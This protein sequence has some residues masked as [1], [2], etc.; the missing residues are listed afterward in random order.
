MDS[1]PLC[2]LQAGVHLNSVMKEETEE[3][4]WLVILE[5]SGGSGVGHIPPSRVPV[6]DKLPYRGWPIQPEAHAV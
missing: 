4:M 5:G 1:P 2:R 6:H 3:N